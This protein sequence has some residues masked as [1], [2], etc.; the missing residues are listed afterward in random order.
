M[1]HRTL[2][3]IVFALLQTCIA[4]AGTPF[5]KE[6]FQ[7][8]VRLFNQH[9][10]ANIKKPF[11]KWTTLPLINKPEGLE[12]V[13]LAS[14]D[15]ATGGFFFIDRAD[16]T[17]SVITTYTF[18]MKFAF[19]SM[20]IE[21]GK[22]GLKAK[23]GGACFS[24]WTYSVF[25]DKAQYYVFVNE[26]YGEIE[27]ASSSTESKL[28]PEIAKLTIKQFWLEHDP[29]EGWHKLCSEGKPD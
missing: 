20:S 16:S 2:F 23:S 28:D 26:C 10:E 22:I 3:L 25:P 19:Y 6:E 4:F 24:Y 15:E 12:V 7:E 17:I 5:T 14:D 27:E 11:D 8:M 21:G 9:Q 1:K 29:I 13:Y 18:P